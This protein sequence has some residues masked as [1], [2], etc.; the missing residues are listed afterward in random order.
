MFCIQASCDLGV[1]ILQ[2][3]EHLQ[4]LEREEEVASG[5]ED[6]DEAA[7]IFDERPRDNWDCESILTSCSTAYNH[8]KKLDAGSVRR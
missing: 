2:A 7:A 1:L 3:K 8:P 6:E 5:P 4:M